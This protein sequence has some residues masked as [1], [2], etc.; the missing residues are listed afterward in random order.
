M[1]KGITFNNEEKAEKTGDYSHTR[2]YNTKEL[3]EWLNRQQFLDILIGWIDNKINRE[4]IIRL[5]N[6]DDNFLISRLKINIIWMLFKT[7]QVGVNRTKWVKEHPD[8]AASLLSWHER[9]EIERE[10]TY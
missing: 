9:M 1:G 4:A 10:K 6:E 5:L 7:L 2:E 8:T 3:A